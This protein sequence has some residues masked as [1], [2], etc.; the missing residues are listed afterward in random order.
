MR[1]IKEVP[2]IGRKLVDFMESKPLLVLALGLVG[3]FA[4]TPGLKKITADFTHTGFFYDDDPML[5]EFNAFE[6][7]FGNDDSVILAV[8][9]P[10]GIFDVE[11]AELLLE[12]TEKMWLLP[13]II[14][15]TSLANYSWVHAEGDD[16]LV[17]PFLPDDIPLTQEL[18][19]ERK[20]IA[21]SHEVI[22]DYLVNKSAD[23]A[24]LYAKLRPGLDSVVKTGPLI[25]A[26]RELAAEMSKGEHQIFVSGGPAINTGFQEATQ[27]D[28]ERLVPF[29]MGL[30]I[31]TL[32]VALRSP[33]AVVLSLS[34]VIFTV[35]AT[36]SMTGLTGYPITS[37]TGILPQILIAI[38]VADAVHILTVFRQARRAG[39]SKEESARYTMLKNFLP[40]VLTSI[41][42]SIGFFSFGTANLSG[43]VGLGVL[44]G[45][46]VLAAWF[47][48]YF[49]LGPL[50]FLLPS[51][52]KPAPEEKLAASL[53][54][55]TSLTNWLSRHRRAVIGSFAVV[56]VGS[57]VLT[58]N[59]RVN[60]DPYLYFKKGL[61]LR[62]AN[63]FIT[64]KV[65]GS[66]GLEIVLR[67]G[68]EDGVK[69]PA[70]LKK[71]EAY[72]A[73]IDQQPGVTR[74]LSIVDILKATNRSLNGDE[75]SMYR[76]ADTKE[77]IGQE[78]FLYTMS[79]PQ[80]MDINDRVTVKSDAL[81]LTVLWTI[82]ESDAWVEARE[83]I[84]AKGQEMGFDMTITGKGNIYQSMNPYVVGSFVRSISV[85]LILISILLIVV[86]GSV[87]L[88]LI[89]L[90]PNC[91][92]LI[93]GGAVFY[94]IG[95][96]IDIGSVLV[97]SV[98]LGIAVDD[99][100]H[101][102]TNF[103]R[104][105][106]E[107]MPAQEATAEL[108][109]HTSPALIFT[110]IVLVCGFG[111]LAFGSFIPNIYFGIMCA[112]ILSMALFTDMTFLPSLLVRDD[113]E[114]ARA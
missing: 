34:V 46:G 40:T 76:L 41:S 3:V 107:G 91:I 33:L 112:I 9:S 69:E 62:D 78:L 39:K 1:D 23:T 12:V 100:I 56:V 80:G 81:R 24:M 55:A 58:L 52:I 87:R 63:D 74:T 85:A 37:L 77:L 18:L 93:M 59:N 43:L 45:F 79:L 21:L 104:L 64:E 8:H 26:A 31:L 50:L 11:S 53:G 88:G 17:D 15:V 25:N 30:I 113:Q 110:T 32:L 101:M 109:A 29:L 27:N 5:E 20:A 102:L 28:L 92:P 42:T 95:K 7:Q 84:L 94:L 96:D 68:T 14:R 47:V 57:L 16:I 35:I 38:C 98:C 13:D 106:R 97:M 72:Q 2:A 105:R 70:F 4:L 108:I 54:L 73:W 19:D 83:G 89:A 36:F 49:I 22:P 10:D 99:T 65:G 71:V 60:S 6:R 103:H 75:P 86:F 66:R 48:T 51:R 90:I 67:T 82:S 111:T 114:K 44:A 61:P